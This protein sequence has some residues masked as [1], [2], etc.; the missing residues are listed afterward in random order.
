MSPPNIDA[1]TGGL[2]PSGRAASMRRR[3]AIIR[4]T[5]QV[6]RES[7]AE[8][9]MVADVAERAGVS[10]ATVYNLVGTRDRLL[11]SILDDAVDQIEERL[12]AQAGDG[13]LD[14][15]LSVLM[16][17]CDV[18]LDDPLPNRRVLGA[19]GQLGPGAWLVSGLTG[20]LRQG[21]ATAVA[22]GVLDGRRASEALATSI[23]LGFRG[24]LISWAFGLLP[25][26][27]LGQWAELQALYQLHYAA[28][29]AEREPIERRIASLQATA[30]TATETMTRTMKGTTT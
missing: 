28:A 30:E 13:G 10:V 16:V 29:D 15:C 23:Q 7:E 27:R 12:G 8:K 9:L 17:A 19:L 4:E 6:L 1:T 3:A 21:V 20:L 25:D 24:V 18:M 11:V 22:D 14:A 5:R 2:R 26:Q